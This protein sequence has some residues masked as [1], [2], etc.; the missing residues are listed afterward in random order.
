MLL[1]ANWQSLLVSTAAFTASTSYCSLTKVRLKR[2][3]SSITFGGSGTRMTFSTI[4]G[5][6]A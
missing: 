2:R 4:G 3:Y 1:L 6:S 5:N